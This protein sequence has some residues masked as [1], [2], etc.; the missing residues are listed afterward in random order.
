MKPHIFFRLALLIPYVLWI[1]CTILLILLSISN[2]EYYETMDII[3]IPIMF[4]SLGI[5]L[6]FFP[7]S[8]LAVALW[9]WSNDRPV[10]AL[11]NAALLAPILLSVLMMM[12]TGAIYLLTNDFAGFIKDSVYF[13]PM[14]GVLSAAF[15]YF[16][17]GVG[18]MAYKL[19]QVRNLIAIPTPLPLE[20]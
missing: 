4:Y 13:F 17:V 10:I 19:A 15:G 12:E 18:F 2:V 6:W 5:L 11:R 3:Y 20:N 14:Y 9:L 16:C 8:I 1:I 7:Y